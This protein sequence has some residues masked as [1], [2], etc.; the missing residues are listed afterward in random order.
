MRKLTIFLL[1]ITL[2]AMV[3]ASVAQNAVEI[4]IFVEPDSLTVYVPGN[5]PVSLSLTQTPTTTA[6]PDHSAES[7]ARTGVSANAEW[8]PYLPYIREFKGVE[9]VLVPA[10]EFTMGSI[11]TEVDD[12]LAMCNAADSESNCV[13]EWFEDETPA[14][15]QHMAEPYWIDRTEVTRAQYQQCVDTG[16]CEETPASEYSTEPNQP[17]NNVTWIQAKDYCEWREARLPT[18]REWEYAARG[19]DNLIFPWGNTM[20]GNEA[21]HCDTNCAID[22][23]WRFVNEEHDDGFAAT[24]PVDSYETDLSWV[25]AS[26]MAGNFRE[27]VSTIYDQD[28]FTYPYRVDGREDSTAETWRVLRGGSWF[29]PEDVVRSNNRNRGYSVDF[30]PDLGFR[31]A[32]SIDP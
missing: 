24:A 32:R 30:G 10:G 15:S 23:N 3:S 2:L 19:P 17:I 21:N 12:A 1:F 16:I 22:S 26:D 29:M 8:E 9:M 31:C 14:H 28:T 6:T 7:I 18:E 25:G 11:E 4:E 13:R 5:Q 20:Q 27:W